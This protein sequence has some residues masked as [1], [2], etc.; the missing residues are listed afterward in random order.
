MV[1]EW[2]KEMKRKLVLILLTGLLLT[3]CAADKAEDNSVAV[4]SRA[5]VERTEA[6][7]ESTKED[8]D[9]AGDSDNTREPE[10]ADSANQEEASDNAETEEAY[11]LAFEAATMEGQAITSE[12]FADSKLTMLNV[13]ATYCGP[14]LNEMPDLG[15]IAASYDKSDFQMLG[16]ISDVVAEDVKAWSMRQS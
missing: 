8:V 14:C 13:W 16:I 2:V 7:T 9:N 15:E 12:C 11:I 4:T 3:G 5:Q 10:N 6:V 1:H